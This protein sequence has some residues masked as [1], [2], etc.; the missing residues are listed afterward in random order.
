VDYLTGPRRE[1]A[2]VGPPGDPATR[3]LVAVARE[4]GGPGAVA[5][6]GDPGDA[7]A[8]AAAPLLAGRSLV[9]GR[10]VAYVCRDFACRAPVTDPEALRA[11]LRA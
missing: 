7:E 3:A 6:C 9:D 11:E 5:A 2:I 4:E 8:V 10:P 1:I